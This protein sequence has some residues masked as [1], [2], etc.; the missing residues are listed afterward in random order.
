M[1]PVNEPASAAARPA[2]DSSWACASAC[3]W[4][5]ERCR[6]G[7]VLKKQVRMNE[8]R[9]TAKPTQKTLTVEVLN[10]VRNGRVR[11]GA[12]PL[13]NDVSLTL[14]D[15]PDAESPSLLV[16]SFAIDGTTWPTQYVRS[17]AFDQS[18]ARDPSTTDACALPAATVSACCSACGSAAATCWSMI[19]WAAEARIVR[20]A[21]CC[22]TAAVTCVVTAWSAA[23]FACSAP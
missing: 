12:A 21:T 3:S 17:P 2:S 10:P 16:I 4:S 22:S 15:E 18:T 20:A 6:S 19:R 13:R 23:A 14:L 8:S 11:R 7:G 5:A 9:I 1:G